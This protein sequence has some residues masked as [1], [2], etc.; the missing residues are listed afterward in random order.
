MACNLVGYITYKQAMNT[1]VPLVPDNDQVN[2][3][4]AGKI[5]NFAIAGQNLRPSV[6]AE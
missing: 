5:Q 6:L 4:L 2:G 3:V 1:A